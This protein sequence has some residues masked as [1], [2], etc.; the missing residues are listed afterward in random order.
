MLR[1][2]FKTGLL[3]R[4]LMPFFR[5]GL[6]QS[7]SW[8]PPQLFDLKLKCRI[9][10]FSYYGGL[11]LKTQHVGRFLSSE[12]GFSSLSIQSPPAWPERANADIRNEKPL[13]E[14]KR[15][16]QAIWQEKSNQRTVE[17]ANGGGGTN[18][19]DRE[20]QIWNNGL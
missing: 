9:S 17:R 6:P 8:P 18:S 5:S 4:R 11:G 3:A 15:G 1:F 20:R 7:R 2:C 10:T 13:G 12:L 19:S 16:K 14:T